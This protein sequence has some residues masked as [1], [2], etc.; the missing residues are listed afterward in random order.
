MEVTERFARAV[1]T[2]L[3]GKPF[4][5]ERL[6]DGFQVGYALTE[7][8]WWSILQANNVTDSITYTVRINEKKQR[9]SINDTLHQMSWTAGASGMVPHAGFSLSV[10]SGRVKHGKVIQLGIVPGGFASWCSPEEER[11]QIKKIGQSLGLKPGPG[12]SAMIGLSVAIGS[13]ALCGVV[14]ALALIIPAVTG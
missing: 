2:Q 4:T 14:F 3:N 5:L 7:S 6:E 8:R 10:K 12:R 9:F 11:A 1:E 13:L